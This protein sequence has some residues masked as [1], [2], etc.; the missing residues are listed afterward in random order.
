M[1]LPSPHNLTTHVALCTA[2]MLMTL[3]CGNGD[4]RGEDNPF[5]EDPP[6]ME[7]FDMKVARPPVVEGEDHDDDGWLDEVEEIIGTDHTR[8]DVPCA[9]TSYSI[10]ENLRIPSADFVFIV[11]TSGSMAEELPLIRNGMQSF[12]GPLLANP[13][14]DF[15]V[16]FIGS[17][18]ATGGF[19]LDPSI[20][21]SFECRTDRPTRS[22][23]FLHYDRSVNSGDSLDILIDSFDS[24]D[25]QQLAPQ[26]WREFLRD[27]ARLVMTVVTDDNAWTKGSAF[28]EKFRRLDRD[29]VYH[30]A[31]GDPLYIFHSIIGV[32]IPPGA[33]SWP[34][35]SAVQNLSCFSAPNS[36]KEYQGLSIL[37]GGLRFS[38]CQSADYASML[39]QSARTVFDDGYI[40]CVF[41][42]PTPT[43]KDELAS[44]EQLALQLDHR[45]TSTLLQRV[46]SSAQCAQGD[47]FVRRAGFGQSTVY[48]CPDRCDAIQNASQITLKA[49]TSYTPTSYGGDSPTHGSTCL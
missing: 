8:P 49:A 18:A 21:G 33:T 28:V 12:F 1:H 4:E 3:G 44:A 39:E 15:R 13:Q 17:F 31:Q 47:Y 19:C 41:P 32:S 42:L 43:Q 25:L 27:D 30:D 48:L 24:P 26:G 16:I 5:E 2:L 37:T 23:N 7:V 20:E 11:D 40:P 35:T 9:S 14:L 22:E 6:D 46:S 29:D 38:I 34:A 36:G 10:T 45:G